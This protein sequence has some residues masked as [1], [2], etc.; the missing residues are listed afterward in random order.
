LGG[1]THRLPAPFIVFATQNP[2]EQQGT[3]P[4]PEAQ[5]DRFLLQVIVPYPSESDL[6]EIARRTTQGTS[7][8]LN[9][10]LDAA[11][12]CAMQAA[13]RAMPVPESILEQVGRLIL[14]T[15]PDSPYATDGIKHATLYGSSPRGM[16]A[17]ILAGKV[18]AVMGGRD[19][20]SPEDIAAVAIPALQH[21]VILS[22]HGAAMGTVTSELIEEIVEDDCPVR[23]GA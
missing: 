12:V 20:L 6:L 1:V 19:A 13:I 14:A 10:L 8:Q 21:R 9:P 17:C 18:R 4:L 11:Q 2:I 7:V 22:F 23:M 5:L 15:H 3:F 16:Q